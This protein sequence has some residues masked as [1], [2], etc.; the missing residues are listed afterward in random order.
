MTTSLSDPAIDQG[1]ESGS[2]DSAAAYVLGR[3]ATQRQLEAALDTLDLLDCKQ[4]PRL[5]EVNLK[6]LDDMLTTGDL[7]PWAE[8]TGVA[9]RELRQP[10]LAQLYRVAMFAHSDGDG[11]DNVR[12]NVAAAEYLIRNGRASM[13]SR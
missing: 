3:V 10:L 2:A 12:K 8:A 6:P 4:L 11:E 5:R 7:K 13:F 9:P 1:L